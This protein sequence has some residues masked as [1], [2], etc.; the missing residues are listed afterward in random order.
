[1]S[2]ISYELLMAPWTQNTGFPKS[3]VMLMLLS[4][5]WSNRLFY[6]LPCTCR[7]H[8]HYGVICIKAHTC[9]SFHICPACK[10]GLWER[11][12]FRGAVLWL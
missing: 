2:F 6:Q 7:R 12:A 1:M 5:C 8:L 9:L 10:G 4:S 11:R 3:C